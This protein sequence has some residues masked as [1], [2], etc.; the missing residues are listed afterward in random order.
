MGISHRLRNIAISQINA[1]KERLDRVD[2]EVEVSELHAEL[3][4]RREVAGLMPDRGT[5]RSPEEIAGGSVHRPGPQMSASPLLRHYR[6]LGLEDGA[7]LTAIDAAYAK[8]AERC[9]PDRFVTDSEEAA[10]AAEILRR[11]EAAYNA[12]RDALDPTAGRFDKLEI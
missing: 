10:A 11:V 12:L 4:A 8:L 9:G 5:L 6:V 7:D 3:D 2:A 1:I